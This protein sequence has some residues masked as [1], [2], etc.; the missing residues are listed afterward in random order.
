MNQRATRKTD[1][2]APPGIPTDPVRRARFLAIQAAGGASHV[3]RELGYAKGETVRLWYVD[4][5][6][7]PEHARKLVAMSQGAATLAEIL[8]DAYKGLTAKELGYR[9]T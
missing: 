1:A 8:P 3:G 7:T 4:R 9:P 6:P 5:D 2:A